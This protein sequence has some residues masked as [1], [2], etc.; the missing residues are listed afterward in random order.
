MQQ[1]NNK[2]NL[3]ISVDHPDEINVHVE[4]TLRSPGEAPVTKKYDLPQPG[5]PSASDIVINDAG[6][7]PPPVEQNKS[8]RI[9]SQIR[10][11]LERFRNTPDY[12]TA[13][14]IEN[15]QAH[16]FF[17]L[18]VLLYLLVR[19]IG[20]THYP[21][22]FSFDE[23]NMALIASNFLRDGFHNSTGE[24]LPALFDN[25]GKFNLG[26]TIYLQ[27]IPLWLF[28][29]ADFATRG[30]SA[31][32]SVLAG[33]S[34]GLIL[35]DIFKLRLW[36]VGT[37]ILSMLPAWF[38]FSR[39]AYE[40]T[41]MV[42]FYAG[43]LYFYFLYR[44][45]NT[46]YLY[47]A[48][49]FSSLAFY[50]HAS[51]QILVPVTAL[52]LIISDLPYHLK[53]RRVLLG[54]ILFTGVIALTYLRFR[55]NHAGESEIFLKNLTTYMF[56]DISVG[57]KIKAF[58]VE[59]LSYISPLYW[60]KP[61]VSGNTPRD[62]SSYIMKGYGFLPFY[63]APFAA[64]G[65][66]LSIKKLYSS[67]YRAL[68]IVFLI[69]PSAAAIVL[70]PSSITRALIMVLPFALLSAIGLED[71]LFRLSVAV[72]IEKPI[73]WALPIFMI[74]VAINLH[75]FSDAMRNGPGWFVPNDNTFTPFGANLV[76]NALEEEALKNPANNVVMSPLWAMYPDILTRFYLGDNFHISFATIYDL[77][78]HKTVIS[79]NT[80]LILTA[81]EFEYAK[82]S[83]RF[84]DI[85]TVRI[86]PFPSGEPAFY[87]ARLAYSPEIDSIL[88]AEDAERREPEIGQIT[89]DGQKVTVSYTKSGGI[90]I[91][92][93]F[94]YNPETLYK[95]NEVNPAVFDLSFE[96]PREFKSIFII[97]G[98]GPID[99]EVVFYSE[100]GQEIGAYQASFNEHGVEGNTLT[101]DRPVTA[102]KVRVSVN[103]PNQD[104]WGIVHIW[105][106]QFK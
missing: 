97:H 39:T 56:T 63:L 9:I 31:I 38:L 29:R 59:Y 34:I 72:K 41:T 103:T 98:S 71:I 94:D 54:G 44:F 5:N 70:S 105:D 52:L 43:A 45:K 92:D 3:E 28:G 61:E 48:I 104:S 17:G 49:L 26:T 30:I 8:Q 83:P 16:L 51:A 13:E 1:P 11:G 23:A 10:A 42:S 14:F 20:I 15:R 47:P 77:A 50:S 69:A 96:Q 68:L 53:D 78:R 4:V 12:P 25:T 85:Q 37:L 40:T 86:L 6:V 46:Y 79:K 18:S 106:I 32:V 89:I 91:D 87:F 99:L 55:V 22:Y 62:A 76:F 73:R 64:W 67:A 35:R 95:S 57:E 7:L 74:F 81:A 60:F 24:F 66:W 88:A 2:I 84:S 27:L 102:S 75:T 21:A 90:R 19:I 82:E 80:L 58:F 33:V 36:W 101:L 65:L 100:S 93:L